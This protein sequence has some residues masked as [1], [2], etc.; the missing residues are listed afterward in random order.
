[1]CIKNFFGEIYKLRFKMAQ[2]AL[3]I[4]TYM[5]YPWRFATTGLVFV[6]KILVFETE[7]WL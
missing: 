7:S 3:Y 5:A 1:M 2:N 6:N 4:P